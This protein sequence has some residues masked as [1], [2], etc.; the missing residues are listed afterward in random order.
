ML[1]LL[2]RVRELL[3]RFGHGLGR[4]PSIE[5]S[6]EGVFLGISAG[7]QYRN[8]LALTYLLASAVGRPVCQV[9]PSQK[10]RG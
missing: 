2:E 1:G 7:G 3:L 5:S 4:K 9:K 6:V 10:R 8:E